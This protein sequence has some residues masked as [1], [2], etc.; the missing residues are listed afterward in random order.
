M[1]G[2]DF[3]LGT[4]SKS[5]SKG[6]GT[7]FRGSS[8]KETAKGADGLK[9]GPEANVG[10][11]VLVSTPIGNLGDITARAHG[12]LEDADLIA[13]EDTRVTRRLL[14]A[15]GIPAGNRLRALHMHNEAQA[16]DEIVNAAER[17]QLIAVVS[18]AGMPGISDPGEIIAK[19]AIER[20]VKVSVI[21]G[22]TSLVAALVVSGLPTTPFVFEG[23]LP[24]KGTERA[25]RIKAIVLEERTAV[26]FESPRRLAR[27]LADFKAQCESMNL[28]PSERDIAV[29]R[30]LTKLH[31]EVWRGSLARASE[32]FGTKETRG[33]VV[34]VIGPLPVDYQARAVEMEQHAI[35]VIN[36]LLEAGTTVKEAV[37]TACD[38][39]GVDHRT[40][41]KIALIAK[42][43]QSA[44]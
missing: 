22:A 6:K 5:S 20:R 10:E 42:N 17:G 27:T 9:T 33:E 41:Y 21:P 7:G 26:I 14:S 16:A 43:G 36:G 19:R 39:I 23:F 3:G 11:I 34:L 8:S 30:E 28:M 1:K 18:D 29:V 38:Q 31:E 12:C 2:G 4:A 25:K 15:L 37:A 44:G 24:P 32:F 40:A 13:C 35:M